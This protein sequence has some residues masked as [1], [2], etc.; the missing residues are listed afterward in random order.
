MYPTINEFYYRYKTHL[1]L[2]MDQNRTLAFKDA[3]SRAV[4]PGDV[5]IDF[6][7]GTGILSFFA[8]QAG[9]RHVYAIDETSII[10]YAQK[11]AI[12]NTFNEKI[13]FI[14]KSG[15]DLTTQDIPEMA[16]IIVSEPISSLLIEGDLWS[17]IEY[18]KRFLKKS[19]LII[20][21]SGNLF[22]VPVKSSPRLFQDSEFV[23]GSNNTYKINFLA[24]PR[25]V[26]YESF[27]EAEAWLSKP[28][29]IL[30]YNLQKDT[31]SDTFRNSVEFAFQ[32]SGQ[33]KGVLF[34]FE[35]EIFDDVT[36]SS[37]KYDQNSTYS[38]LFAPTPQQ[39]LI[40]IG[41]KL[42]CRVSH[43]ILTPI[44]KLWTLEFEHHSKLASPEE[45]PIITKFQ[46]Q[47]NIL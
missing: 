43:E 14:R 32:K 31:L 7:T 38:P 6:G 36:L 22:M 12:K 39:P 20:P 15:K 18:L 46:S 2:L 9:A 5:V 26:M 45:K 27:L 30:N 17:S 4:Q 28:A 44:K 33:L 19:G 35:A 41:D 13:T 11:L 24:L 3:I 8:L 34:Y 1:K 10:E 29:P 21:K 47:F 42:V 40:S 37:R 25:N 16:D 23:L